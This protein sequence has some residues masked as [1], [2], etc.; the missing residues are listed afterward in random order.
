MYACWAGLRQQRYEFLGTR[1][2]VYAHSA[3][4]HCCGFGVTLQVREGW[5]W[6]QEVHVSI[7]SQAAKLTPAQ[8]ILTML[9]DSMTHMMFK[10]CYL[11]P[12]FNVNNEQPTG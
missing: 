6:L 12:D 8:L 11:E 7:L 3:A 9:V 4:A 1:C 10:S 5:S 2:R